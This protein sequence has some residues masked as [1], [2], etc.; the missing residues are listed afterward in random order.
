MDCMCYGQQL[1]QQQHCATAPPER[2]AAGWIA[3]ELRLQQRDQ[4]APHEPSI[5]LPTCESLGPVGSLR[6]PFT[7]AAS[8]GE[9]R[10]GRQ[11]QASPHDSVSPA[12]SALRS[13]EA[14]RMRASSSHC[15]VR[16]FPQARNR[17]GP[18]T[19]THGGWFTSARYPCLP[20]FAQLIALILLIRS[21]ASGRE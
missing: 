1:R 14:L 13:R 11:R 18:P 20:H 21:C 4:P 7:R 6:A 9:G 3:W 19:G 5:F 10:G 17:L 2:I 15:S 8:A 12:S 16:A